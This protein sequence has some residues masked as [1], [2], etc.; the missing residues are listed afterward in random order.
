MNINDVPIMII[1]PNN[2]YY[3]RKKARVLKPVKNRHFEPEKI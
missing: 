1:C 2:K 3:L